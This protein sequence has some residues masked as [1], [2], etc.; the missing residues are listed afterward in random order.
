MRPL[1][2]AAAILSTLLAPIALAALPRP[3]QPV[4][5]LFPPWVAPG[6][7]L[8]AVLQAGL[9]PLAAAPVPGGWLA[10][11]DPA[12]TGATEA[13]PGALLVLAAPGARGCAG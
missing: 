10:R 12:R 11:P 7:Q 4:A 5:V 9:L 6:A 1:A 3:G 8:A 2:L 13:V